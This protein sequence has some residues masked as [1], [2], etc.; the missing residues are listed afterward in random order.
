MVILNCS[1][2]GELKLR[3]LAI[4]D[5]VYVLP[6]VVL[7]NEEEGCELL[8]WHV[9]VLGTFERFNQKKK[10][11]YWKKNFFINNSVGL[12]MCNSLIETIKYFWVNIWCIFDWIFSQNC[13]NKFPFFACSCSTSEE[14]KVLDSAVPNELLAANANASSYQIKEYKNSSLDVILHCFN[15]T[16]TWHFHYFYVLLMGNHKIN[17][18]CFPSFHSGCNPACKVWRWL[19]TGEWCGAFHQVVKIYIAS[20]NMLKS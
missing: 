13:R 4:N 12:L 1:Y 18:V 17:P 16:T 7:G 15:T 10:I 11:D 8:K 9:H 2:W 6:R 3:K 20:P 14:Y 5:W 19:R